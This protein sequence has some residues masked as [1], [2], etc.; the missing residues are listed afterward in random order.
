MIL[1]KWKYDIA[2][3][4]IDIAEIEIDIAETVR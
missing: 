2:D 1:K 4:E 3:T